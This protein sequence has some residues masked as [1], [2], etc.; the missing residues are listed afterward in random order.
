MSPPDAGD[1]VAPALRRGHLFGIFGGKI[2]QVYD[3]LDD[4]GPDLI[5]CR[6]E[7]YAAFMA[8]AAGRLTGRSARRSAYS[9]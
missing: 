4:L 6:H 1:R 3:V 7:Q 5:V 8:G 2:D 9:E